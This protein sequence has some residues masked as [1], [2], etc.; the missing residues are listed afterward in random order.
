MLPTLTTQQVCDL[1]GLPVATLNWWVQN[2][3]VEPVEPGGKGPGNA[4]Q[5]SAQQAVKLATVAALRQ[6]MGNCSQEYV[7]RILAGAKKL[8]DDEMIEWVTARFTGKL[9][10]RQQEQ[11]R[12]NNQKPDI[13][14][15]PAF[16]A[17]WKK[18]VDR[19]LAV[20]WAAVSARAKSTQNQ[21][22]EPELVCN[23]DH[24]AKHTGKR[25]LKK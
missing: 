14:N 4:H 2:S 17:D 11:A 19:I 6:Y 23:E 18:R 22:A 15:D 9:S 3:Y 16:T 13:D 10:P 25:R 24:S 8:T 5:F 1:V 7:K 20:V 12:T 21:S